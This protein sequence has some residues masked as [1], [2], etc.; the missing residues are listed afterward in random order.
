[1]Y[2]L[3]VSYFMSMGGQGKKILVEIK[4]NYCLSQIN[5]YGPKD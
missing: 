1:M 5:F 2:F 3:P 4:K